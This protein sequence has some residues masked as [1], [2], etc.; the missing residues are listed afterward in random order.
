MRRCQTIPKDACL[1]EEIAR[2]VRL[3]IGRANLLEGDKDRFFFDQNGLLRSFRY[4][5]EEW[6]EIAISE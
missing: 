3:R 6:D 2:L 1:I 5:Q 4:N